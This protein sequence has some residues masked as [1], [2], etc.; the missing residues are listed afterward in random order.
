MRDGHPDFLACLANRALLRRLAQIDEA[1]RIGPLAARGFKAA[2]DQQRAIAV[3]DDASGDQ[4]R[5]KEVHESAFDADLVL[6]AIGLDDAH[7]ERAAAHRAESHIAREFM[8][9]LMIRLDV[10]MSKM[11]MMSVMVVLHRYTVSRRT[12]ASPMRRIIAA[13]IRYASSDARFSIV[14]RVISRSD[15]EG[16]RRPP[17]ADVSCSSSP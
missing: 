1:A 14:G 16:L 10:P 4:L 3:R 2:P 15:V 11:I 12:S 17:V 13:T 9:E 8:L 5:R 7:L 6:L